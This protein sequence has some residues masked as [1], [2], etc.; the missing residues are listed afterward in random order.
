MLGLLAKQQS[1]WV[2]AI[3]REVGGDTGVEERSQKMEALVG[4]DEDFGSYST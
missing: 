2:R 3:I 1:D 4:H